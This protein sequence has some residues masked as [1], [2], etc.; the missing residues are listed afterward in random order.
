[1]TAMNVQIFNKGFSETFWLQAA[2]LA[3][4]TLALIALG[5]RYVW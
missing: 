3:I 2:V 1:V 4:A 5:A